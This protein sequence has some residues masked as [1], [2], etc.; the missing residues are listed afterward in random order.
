M[1]SNR[2][3]GQKVSLWSAWWG[4]F[5]INPGS[6]CFIVYRWETISFLFNTVHVE[7]GNYLKITKVI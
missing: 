6:L 7:G 3:C 5:G 1:G 4:G 2:K